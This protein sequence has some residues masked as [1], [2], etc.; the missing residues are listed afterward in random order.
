MMREEM[1]ET[2]FMKGPLYYPKNNGFYSVGYW[3]LLKNIWLMKGV[4]LI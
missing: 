2:V 4:E 3:E 1:G